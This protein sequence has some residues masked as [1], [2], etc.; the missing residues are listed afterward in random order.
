M[1]RTGFSCRGVAKNGLEM[2]VGPSRV[3]RI[4]FSS[5]FFATPGLEM[6]SRKGPR[7][8]IDYLLNRSDNP[9]K[10]GRVLIMTKR[11]EVNIQQSKYGDSIF[12]HSSILRGLVS[13]NF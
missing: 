5:R 2:V 3:S 12:D 13:P 8:K 11:R 1:S 9:T 4:G 10:T 6:V 7:V